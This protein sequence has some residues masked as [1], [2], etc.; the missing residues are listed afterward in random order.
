[1]MMTS[2]ERA[3]TSLLC[4]SAKCKHVDAL[5][6]HTADLQMLEKEFRANAAYAML[7]DDDKE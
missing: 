6:V 2:S 1:M 4:A 5:N 7:D 3:C